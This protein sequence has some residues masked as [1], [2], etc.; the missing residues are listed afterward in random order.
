[1]KYYKHIVDGVFQ[2]SYRGRKNY[3]M[4]YDGTKWWLVFA[5]KKEEVKDIVVPLLR[6]SWYNL[7]AHFVATG[8]WIPAEL[9][10]LT[11]NQ[12]LALVE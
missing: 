10:E 7:C 5:D 2:D 11:P 4:A 8:E 6:T 1:M 9:S 12:E 3:L